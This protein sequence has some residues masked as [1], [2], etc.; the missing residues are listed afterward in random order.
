MAGFI[1]FLRMVASSRL[2]AKM[3]VRKVCIQDP[4]IA[5]L[6]QEEFTLQANDI[7]M[8]DAGVLGTQ[9]LAALAKIMSPTQICL[10]FPFTPYPPARRELTPPDDDIDLVVASAWRF[11]VAVSRFVRDLPHVEQVVCH[12]IVWEKMVPFHPG[13]DHIIHFRRYPLVQPIPPPSWYNSPWPEFG[14]APIAGPDR[15]SQMT[16]AVFQSLLRRESPGGSCTFVDCAAM[17]RTMLVQPEWGTSQGVEQRVRDIL[18][19]RAH[20]WAKNIDCV[21]VEDLQKRVSFVGADQAENKCCVCG[22]EV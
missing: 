6:Q 21:D 1:S 8:D 12:D 10:H 13:A 11:E 19:T 5:Q 18:S 4:A 15:V 20:S 22:H 14:V 16:C 17:V 7:E 3:D 2:D 9:L